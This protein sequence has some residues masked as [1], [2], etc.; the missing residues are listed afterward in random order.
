MRL[1]L[2]VGWL[3]IALAVGAMGCR[4]REEDQQG[5]QARQPTREEEQMILDLQRRLDEALKK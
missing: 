3:A 2:T 1:S 5:E 4:R